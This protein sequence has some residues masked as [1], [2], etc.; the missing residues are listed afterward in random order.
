MLP[1]SGHICLNV[2]IMFLIARISLVEEQHVLK[3]E[4]VS[5]IIE[6]AVCFLHKNCRFSLLAMAKLKYY[7][8]K[9]SNVFHINYQC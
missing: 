3:T 2:K 9:G 4:I 5:I 7:V 1:P 8:A 6:D